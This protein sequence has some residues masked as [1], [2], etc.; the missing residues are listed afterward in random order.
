[1]SDLSE[2]QQRVEQAERRFGLMATHQAKASA[3]LIELMDRIERQAAERQAETVEG[4]GVTAGAGIEGGDLGAEE[5]EAPRAAP[6]TMRG[7]L[8]QQSVAGRA[9]Q[10]RQSASGDRTPAARLNINA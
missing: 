1:M 4:A 9:D 6:G 2:L 5:R 10:Y 8:A 7:A 3:R